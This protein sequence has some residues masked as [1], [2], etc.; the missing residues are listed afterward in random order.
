MNGGKTRR[1]QTSADKWTCRRTEQNWKTSIIAQGKSRADEIYDI[2]D[3]N[4][5]IDGISY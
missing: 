4:I 5:L 3:I 1:L 2:D